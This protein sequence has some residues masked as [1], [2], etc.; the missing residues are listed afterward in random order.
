MLI[1]ALQVEMIKLKRTLALWM[2]LIA[3]LSIVFLMTLNMLNA[4]QRFL[5]AGYDP[6][7]FLAKNSIGLWTLLMLPLF[8]SLETALL[9]NLEHSNNTWK[10]LFAL[11]VARSTIYLSKQ[12]IALILMAASTLLLLVLVVLTVLVVN[13]LGLIP[14]ADMTAPIPWAFLVSTGMITFLSSVL[15]IAIHTWVGLRWHNFTVSLG[16]GIVVTVASFIIVN[17]EQG[18]YFPWAMPTRAASLLTLADTSVPVISLIM[19]NIVGACVITALGM[20][21]I[22]RRDI[23]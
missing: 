23:L 18:Y 21:D 19:I 2:V 10:H 1:R 14:T 7:L 17:A 9:G 12:L 6:W 22:R 8:I 16:F 3:P 15:I 20:W 5:E 4:G 13:G 11:P